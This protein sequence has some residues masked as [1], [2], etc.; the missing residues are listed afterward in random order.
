MSADKFRGGESGAPSE[1]RHMAA[2]LQKLVLSPYILHQVSKTLDA[3]P[4][5]TTHLERRD[6]TDQQ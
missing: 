3:A 5:H 6:N 4:V 2:W 1:S